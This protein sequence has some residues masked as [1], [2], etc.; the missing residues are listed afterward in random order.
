MANSNDEHTT[1]VFTY[2]PGDC[3]LHICLTDTSAWFSAGDISRIL[4]EGSSPE[5]LLSHL[6]EDEKKAEYVNESGVYRLIFKVCRVE[7]VDFRQWFTSE[8]LPGLRRPFR[9]LK[10]DFIDLRSCPYSR[11]SM[12]GY[13]VR[14]IEHEGKQ[15]YSINDVLRSINSRTDSCRTAFRL[16]SQRIFVVKLLIYGNTQPA[17]FTVKAGIKLIEAGGR[18]KIKS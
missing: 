9:K 8:A 7:P 18:L 2:L 14:M 15:M 5:E 3:P 4:F 1:H 16:R 17:W 13:A 6:S 11:E 10:S 12:H